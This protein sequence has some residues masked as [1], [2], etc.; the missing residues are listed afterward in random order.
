MK[1]IHEQPAVWGDKKNKK[2]WRTQ[3][4]GK[5]IVQLVDEL[6]RWQEK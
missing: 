6:H 3:Q 1:G 4:H 2:T 5:V